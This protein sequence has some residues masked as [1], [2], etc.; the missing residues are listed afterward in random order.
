M[1]IAAFEEE[2][3]GEWIAAASQSAVPTEKPLLGGPRHACQVHCVACSCCLLGVGMACCMIAQFH[4]K[5]TLRPRLQ[6]VD[7][8]RLQKFTDDPAG[9]KNDRQ[10]LA[11][12]GSA[13]RGTKILP[14]PRYARCSEA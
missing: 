12:T 7:C 3:R 11:T 14:S 2:Q 5:T 6:Q 1:N 9:G 8:H 13:L 4:P 10:Y